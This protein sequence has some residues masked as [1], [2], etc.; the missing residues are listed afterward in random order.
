MRYS[1]EALAERV[2]GFVNDLGSIPYDGV[3]VC[4]DPSRKCVLVLSYTDTPEGVRPT[5]A[6][7]LSKISHSRDVLDALKSKYP[8]FA[9]AIRDATLRFEFCRDYGN[10]AYAIARLDGDKLDWIGRYRAC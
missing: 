9:A 5:E 10:G 8:S 3:V 2:A 1:D 6:E 7:V 4:H